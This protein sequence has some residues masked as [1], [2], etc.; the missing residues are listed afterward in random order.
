MDLNVSESDPRSPLQCRGVREEEGDGR[1]PTD[2]AE[3]VVER[4]ILSRTVDPRPGTGTTRGFRYRGI[5][6]TGES[7]SPGPG[8]DRKHGK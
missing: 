4:G 2:G 7:C 1:C 3:G 8:P 6:G 5:R